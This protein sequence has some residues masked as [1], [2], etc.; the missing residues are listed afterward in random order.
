MSLLSIASNVGG[1]LVGSALSGYGAYKGAKAAG[2]QIKKGMEENESMSD[3]QRQ[4]QNSF[5]SPYTTQGQS[6]LSDLS[7]YRMREAAPYQASSFGRVDMS[8]DPG[9]QYRMD[10]STKALDASASA[11]GSLFSGAQ[12]KALQE[13]AQNL[14][15]QEFD[16]AYNRQ[17]GQWK[18]SEDAKRNQYNT[19]ADRT[20]SYD[21]Y[22][23]NQ[24]QD[25]ANMGLSATGS[26]SGAYQNIG[27]NEL[28]N[29][30]MLR[31]NYATAKA[32]QASLPWQ[33]AGAMSSGIGNGLGNLSSYYMGKK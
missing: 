24:L 12:Q 4:Q 31:G 9:A 30:M 6:S 20:M 22:R 33:T 26:L 15:S 5:Y 10:Q 27:G 2:K 1:N 17:Y 25:L 3:E 11:K 21:Q 23:M 16:N 8:Q 13:N 29:Q 7:N 19:E 18:D 32:N 14:A 28:Q